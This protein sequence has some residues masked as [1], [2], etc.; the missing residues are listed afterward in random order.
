MAQAGGDEHGSD[1][2]LQAAVHQGHLEL[3]LEVRHGAEATNDHPGTD[4]PGKADRQPVKGADLDR[5][6]FAEAVAD[7]ANPLLSGEERLLA[8]LFEDRDHHLMA[9]ALGAIDDVG[10][11]VRD[12]LAAA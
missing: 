10:V 5:W 7:H 12:G 2:R 11:A 1:L 9:V 4:L 3:A 8:G 6:P